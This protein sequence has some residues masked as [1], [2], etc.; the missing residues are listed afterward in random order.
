MSDRSKAQPA[1]TTPAT[2]DPK[3]A[4]KIE[5][6]KAARELGRRMRAGKPLVF[7]NRHALD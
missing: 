4:E 7:R 6:A 3:W 1:L 2:A 5:L